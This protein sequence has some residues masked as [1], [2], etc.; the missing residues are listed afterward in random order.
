VYLQ[1]RPTLWPGTVLKT[2]MLRPMRGVEV[3]GDWLAWPPQIWDDALVELPQDFYLRE[4]ME[5]EPDDL[6]AVADIMGKY[7]LMFSHDQEDLV[8]DQRIELPEPIQ[9]SEDAYSVEPR[10]HRDEVRLHLELAQDVIRTWIALQSPDNYEAVKELAAP[11]LAAGKAYLN[12]PEQ[13]AVE[14][15]TGQEFE[16]SVLSVRVS[17]V[18][19]TMNAALS[20]IHV[21]AIRAVF[22]NEEKQL[23]GHHTVYSTC[24]LQLYNHMVEQATLKY[25][26]NENCRRP[27]VRQR[28]RS[29]YDQNRLEG[30]M[31]CSKNCARAQ[32]QRELRRRRAASRKQDA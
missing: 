26:A 29:Q 16:Y 25:C 19:E 3:Q 6:H 21:G 8:E 20:S 2:P 10:F 18:T 13:G 30:V 7:G 5:I 22:P 1:F 31:Y 11:E 32:A 27:F 9:V 12:H 28:G 24:F 15:I 23:P 17:R 14:E 4:L